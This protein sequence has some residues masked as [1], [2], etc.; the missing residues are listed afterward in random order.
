MYINGYIFW[1]NGNGWR[2]GN[3][4]WGWYDI[5]IHSINT[6]WTPNILQASSW[7]LVNGGKKKRLGF[8]PFVTY[9]LLKKTNI[10]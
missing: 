1:T 2:M 7:A 10:K 9:H 8:C 4:G 3:K 5:G 6:Y